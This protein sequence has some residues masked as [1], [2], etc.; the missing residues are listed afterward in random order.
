MVS[1]VVVRGAGDKQGEDIEDPLLCDVS[2]QLAR[3]RKELDAN[4][5]VPQEVVLTT[6]YRE[7]L[8]N[9]QL[10]EVND[11]AQGET[12]RGK[13]TGITHRIDGDTVNT[14]VTLRKPLKET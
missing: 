9:G 1:I 5:A 2:V 8:E 3:G 6:I 4:G 13:V 7:G 12:Y 10:S 14:E 11:A